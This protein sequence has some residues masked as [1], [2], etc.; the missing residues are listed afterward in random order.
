M[1]LPREARESLQWR[2][3]R[4]AQGYDSQSAVP[5]DYYNLGPNEYPRE[6]PDWQDQFTQTPSPG[7]A[8]T[9]KKPYNPRKLDVSRLVTLPPPYPRHH[10]AVNNNHP[11]LSNSRATLRNLNDESQVEKVRREYETDPDMANLRPESPSSA[12]CRRQT[13]RRSIQQRVNQGVTSFA[14]AAEEEANFDAQEQKRSRRQASQAFDEFKARVMTPLNA[15]YAQK[16]S[17]ATT[18]LDELGESLNSEARSHNPN[19]TQEE[20]D[21]QP[22]LL[23]KLTLMKWLHEARDHLHKG[24]FEL[25]SE[26]DSRYKELILS[27]YRQ[28]GNHDKV[29][30]V[31]SFFSQDIKK[32]K[33]EYELKA[34]ERMEVFHKTVEDH[35]T[36][37][38]EVQLSAF[39]DIA[40]SLH[41]IIQQVPQH[42]EGFDIVIPDEEYQESPSYH[43]HPMQYLYTLLEHTGK[44]A[45]QFIES[46]TNLLC[47]LHEVK[48]GMMT[49][50]CRVQQTQ[51]E[52]AGEDV[53]LVQEEIQQARKVGD[54]SLT[55]DLKERV[56]LVEE[57]WRQALG[58]GLEDLQDR[59]KT[60]LFETGGW[61]ENMED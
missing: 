14:E 46:Q 2:Q 13:F 5:G 50:E 48:T 43:E 28:M 8:G 26:S 1:G 33:S 45:Y 10:P 57:Q 51:R 35:V 41:T 44:S 34:Q 20:G 58:K 31:E 29:R 11:D 61:D 9:P 53:R 7:P 4:S 27:P 12:T 39:W 49:A 30:E 60:F 3:S 54:R 37:G 22:E 23:E 32:R 38:V 19:Q 25:E 17:Q 24:Q 16:I 55:G 59:I 42:L 18:A 40:P 15:L 47:L 56:G 21:E 52:L 36:R 6:K